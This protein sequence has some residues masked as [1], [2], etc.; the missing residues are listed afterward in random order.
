MYCYAV[1]K[2]LDAV[3]WAR[4]PLER[5]IPHLIAASW[6]GREVGVQIKLLHYM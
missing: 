5:N 2:S 6:L 4:R 3:F 1:Y